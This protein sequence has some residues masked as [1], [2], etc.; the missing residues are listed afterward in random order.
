[1]SETAAA[2]VELEVS[3]AAAALQDAEI[4][5]EGDTTEVRETPAAGA[6][7]AVEKPKSNEDAIADLRAQLR[8]YDDRVKAAERAANDARSQLSAVSRN[9]VDA[10]LNMIVSSIETVSGASAAA[11]ADYQ[12]AME[13]GDYAKAAEAQEK[14][15]DARANLLRLQERK[16]EVES[17][18]GQVQAAPAQLSEVESIASRLSPASAAWI[19]AHPEVAKDFGAAE[20]AHYKALGDGVAVDTPAYF[21]RIEMELGMREA[22]RVEPAPQPRR[23]ASQAPVTQSAPSLQTGQPTRQVV[24]LTAAEREMAREMDM[25][26]REYALAKLEAIKEGKIGQVRH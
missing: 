18:R 20:R 13:A 26:D 23:V 25:T 5:I 9:A 4:T 8:T 12:R 19:R 2:E 3:P 16:A 10:T 17:G 15:A 7:P 11:K 1:M 21:E 22:K 6:A 14:M 24:T